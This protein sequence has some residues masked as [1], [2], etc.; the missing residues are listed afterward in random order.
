MACCEAQ[1]KEELQIY[2]RTAARSHTPYRNST[3][4]L[5]MTC[6][7]RIG[8]PKKGTTRSAELPCLVPVS[9]SFHGSCFPRRKYLGANHLFQALKKL[10]L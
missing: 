2:F 1:H 5:P 10:L 7:V 8:Q 9:R 4:K 3:L 6:C